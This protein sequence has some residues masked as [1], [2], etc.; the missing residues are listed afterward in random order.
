MKK[1]VELMI[2]CTDIYVATT[3]LYEKDKE[4]SKV[5][6]KCESPGMSVEEGAKGRCAFYTR[7]KARR[8]ERDP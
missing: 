4:G 2:K 7:Q 6:V 1:K 8:F 3:S 5:R